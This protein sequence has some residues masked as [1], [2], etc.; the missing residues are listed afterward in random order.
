MFNFSLYPYARWLLDR[1]QGDVPGFNIDESEVPPGDRALTGR[2]L[3]APP[4]PESPNWPQAPGFMLGSQN[5]LSSA[6][7]TDAP[8]LRITPGN[9]LPGFH[10][11]PQDELTNFSLN[12][13]DSLREGTWPGEIPPDATT[14]EYGDSAPTW[15]LPPGVEDPAQPVPSEIPDW[16]YKLM[17][18]PLPPL[19]T[20]VDPQTRRRIVPYGPL[21]NPVRSYQGTDQN[22]PTAGNVPPYVGGINSLPDLRSVEARGAEQWPFSH[23]SERPPDTNVRTGAANAQNID[24]QS[25]AREATWNNRPQPLTVGQPYAQVNGG[26]RQD[27]LSAG[28][29]RQAP[30]VPPTLSVRPVADPNLILANAGDADVQQ[31]Q[32]QGL[33]PQDKQTQ[34]QILASSPGTGRPDAPP[35]LRAPEKPGTEMTAAERQP[36]KELSQFV[37]ECRRAAAD[38]TQELARVATR[39]GTRVYEDT[40]RKIGSDMALLAERFA[41]DPGEAADSLLASFPQTRV[42]GEFFA[43]FAAVFTILANAVRGGEFERAVLKAME[44]AKNKTKIGVEGVGRSVPDILNKGI[45]EIK[46]GVEIDSSPQLRTHYAFAKEERVPFNLVVGPATRRV[47]KSVQDLVYDTGGTIQRF[48]PATGSFTPFQ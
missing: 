6:L 22:V 41:D 13:D 21:V 4:T 40:I 36:D 16:L 25:A 34:Q 7:P 37:E 1:S 35:A 28:M 33:P 44:A 23:T 47:S 43:G 48:D 19:S 20:A 38:L 26:K 18:M 8:G 29:E 17:T 42:E 14:P 32:Q 24:P 15:T 9:N 12:E 30:S 45:T 3:A 31:A 46:S 11:D 39:F 10:L 5:A 27:P 2:M